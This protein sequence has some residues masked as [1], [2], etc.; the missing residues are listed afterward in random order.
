MLW[1]YRNSPHESTNE[2]PSF[3]IFGTDCRSPTEAA[4]LPSSPVRPVEVCDYRE[5]LILSLSSAHKLAA[6]NIR[7]AQREYKEHYD[8]RARPT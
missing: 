3:L 2:K 5:E 7:N 8:E 4:L 1:A 6:Q